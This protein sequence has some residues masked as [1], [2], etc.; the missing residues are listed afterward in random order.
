MAKSILDS[1]IS[2]G[3]VELSEAG[4][5]RKETKDKNVSLE[6]VLYSRGIKETEVAEAKSEVFGYPIK[7]LGGGQILHEL[8]KEIPEE[9]ARHYKFIPLGKNEGYLDIGM[10]NPEDVPAQE[11]LKFIGTR[12]GAPLRIFIITPSDFQNV[13]T[14]Y[15]SLSGE[16]TKALGEFQ[17]EFESLGE[18]VKIRKEGPVKIVEDAP[19]TKMM[20]VILRHAVEGGASDIH[21]EPTGENVR[22]RFRVDGVLHTSLML[23]GDVRAALITRIKVMTNL[24]IDET[25]IPQDGR[26]HAEVMGRPIDFRVST[27]PAAFGEKAAIRILDPESGIVN[28]PNLGLEGRNLTLL[29]ENIRRP[30]GLIL[31]TGPTGSGKSTTLYALLK[32]LNQEKSNIVSLEDP[33]EYYIPGINQSQIRPEINYTFATGLRSIF[34]QD[35]D[36]IMVGEIRDKETAELAVHAALTGHLVLSTLHTNNAIGVI[37]RMLDM[38][39]DPFLLPPTLILAVGQRLV[40]TLCKDSRKKVKLTGKFKDTTMEAVD[41]MPP[42]L[43]DE[44]KKN[45][46]SEIYQA[47]VSPTCPKGTRGRTGIFEVLAMTPE[48]EKIILT[49]PSESKIEAEAQ[50][51]GMVTLKQDGIIK[52]LKGVIGIEELLEVT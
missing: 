36:I 25:R 11:A 18:E 23:P 4:K 34:R 27:F 37:P 39:I 35:P 43:R 30:F 40:R 38:G 21:I 8:L 1:L 46:P 29:E 5:I 51:Q 52:V 9:S 20:G 31:I 50:R 41:K 14:E 16:I 2:R 44:V 28:L 26:F 33:I 47:E 48:L 22:V 6:D 10:L 49:E 42:S 24:K 15:R 7:Y 17:K 3:V 13:M 12:T 32:I 19:V 45:I